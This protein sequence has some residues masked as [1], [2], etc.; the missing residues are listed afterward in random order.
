MV[1]RMYISDDHI[2]F[3]SLSLAFAAFLLITFSFTEARSIGKLPA[4]AKQAQTAPALQKKAHIKKKKIQFR[5]TLNRKGSKTKHDV[6]L[7]ILQAGYP[8]TYMTYIKPLA[9]SGLYQATCMNP[10]TKSTKINYIYNV[11]SGFIHQL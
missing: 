5:S 8:C 10:K 11:K 4:I 2:F 3:G 9:L 6:A 1:L 7:A